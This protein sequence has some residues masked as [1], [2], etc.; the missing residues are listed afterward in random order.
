MREILIILRELELYGISEEV[1][2]AKGKFK[3]AKS[4]KDVKQK[5]K[6]VHKWQQ[7]R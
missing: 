7:R 4:Y 2:V 5:V 6:R 3:V 1:E